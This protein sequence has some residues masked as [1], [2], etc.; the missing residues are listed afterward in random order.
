[1]VRKRISG[2]SFEESF[3]GI[4][5]PKRHIIN[6]PI[7]IVWNEMNSSFIIVIYL[8][9]YYRLRKNLDLGHVYPLRNSLVNQALDIQNEVK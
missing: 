5:Q 4:L 8:K 3:T 2:V 9:N 6:T 7:D 1:M